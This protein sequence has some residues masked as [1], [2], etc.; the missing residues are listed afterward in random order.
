MP[1]D[2]LAQQQIHHRHNNPWRT[3]DAA[4]EAAL[5]GEGLQVEGALAGS[6]QALEVDLAARRPALPTPDIQRQA[7]VEGGL[8]SQHVSVPG[9]LGQRIGAPPSRAEDA[10]HVVSRGSVEGASHTRP[11]QM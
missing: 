3:A 2:P 11:R 7:R 8:D 10:Q 5:L 1:S 6:Q 9:V 4:P